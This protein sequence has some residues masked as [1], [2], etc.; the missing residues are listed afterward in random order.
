MVSGCLVLV[1]GIP[2]GL[3]DVGTEGGEEASAHHSQHRHPGRQPHHKRGRRRPPPLQE[4]LGAPLAP[5][6][7]LPE[8]PAAQGAQLARNLIRL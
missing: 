7:A 2:V 8:A 5:G 1:P 4:L 3:D 6:V